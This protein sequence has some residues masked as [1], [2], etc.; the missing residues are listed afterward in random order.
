M[1]SGAIQVKLQLG[2]FL[3]RCPWLSFMSMALPLRLCGN[4]AK[5]S[6]TGKLTI[7]VPCAQSHQHAGQ[8]TQC[9]SKQTCN[10][11]EVPSSVIRCH[12]ATEGQT[13]QSRGLNFQSDAVRQPVE[14]TRTSRC[15]ASANSKDDCTRHFVQST[16]ES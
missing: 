7:Q 14:A 16:A 6:S 3:L 11:A 12:L 13:Q 9:E 10:P 2:A 4:D 1:N 15:Y 8:H 5:A